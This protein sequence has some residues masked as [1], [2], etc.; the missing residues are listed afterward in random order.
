MID[1]SIFYKTTLPIN[2]EWQQDSWDLFLSAYTPAER[3]LFSFG[4]ATADKKHWLIF[5]EYNFKHSEIPKEDKFI[6]A[7][8]N[9]AEYISEYWNWVNNSIDIDKIKICVD[10]TGFIRPYLIFLIKWFKQIGITKFDVI[11]SEP[12]IYM[13]REN[14]SFSDTAIK[15]VRQV[16]GYEG[17]HITDTSK[18]VLIIGVGYEEHLISY[19]AENK[20]N[21]RKIQLFGFPSLSADMYQ[22]NVLMAQRAEEEVGAESDCYFAP[23]NDPFITA[24]VL[25]GIVDGLYSR[26]QLTNLYLCPISTKPQAL[27]FALFHLNS[28]E[29]LPISIIYPY[30]ESYTKETSTGILKIWKYTVEL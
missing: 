24:N 12:A 11:Y 6:C 29:T 1:Y 21:A 18:D 13:K 28:C 5:P 7:L 26:R 17:T 9:E 15:E 30:S 27:G 14:T 4:K 22:E 2:D 20:A 3:V 8:E 10:I 19:A 25:A 23:A 16:D